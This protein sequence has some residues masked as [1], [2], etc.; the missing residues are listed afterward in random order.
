[1]PTGAPTEKNATL[2]VRSSCSSCSGLSNAPVVS[3]L[4]WP[5][6]ERSREERLRGARRRADGAAEELERIGDEPVI[7]LRNAGERVGVAQHAALQVAE[8]PAELA[9]VAIAGLGACAGRGAD[10]GDRRFGHARRV[11]RAFPPQRERGSAARRRPHVDHRAARGE[12]A[13]QV[14]ADQVR[15]GRQLLQRVLAGLVGDGERGGAAERGD[16]GAIERLADARR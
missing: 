15:P 3:R 2:L 12:E 4:T 6:S 1:M 5:P 9:L 16:D 8:A 13:G 7:V 11:G 14:H 10:G